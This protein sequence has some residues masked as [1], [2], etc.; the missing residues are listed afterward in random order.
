M[1]F[2]VEVAR[3]GETGRRKS[4]NEEEYEGGRV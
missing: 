4:M 1:V 2:K 3:N